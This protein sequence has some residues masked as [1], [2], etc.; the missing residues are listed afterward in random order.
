MQLPVLPSTMFS[1]PRLLL[2]PNA[3]RGAQF[4]ALRTQK[5]PF[6]GG[7]R[8]IVKC[9]WAIILILLP[10]LAN[11]S[12]LGNDWHITMRFYE[13]SKTCWLSA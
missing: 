8:A 7:K 11:R 5:S 1:S 9:G 10:K 6:V 13:G 2:N 4:A 12:E 3:E